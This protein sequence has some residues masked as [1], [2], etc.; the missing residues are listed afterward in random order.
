VS[1]L[2]GS[3]SIYSVLVVVVAVLGV[4]MSVVHVVE[5]VLVLHG[6]MAAPL[7]VPVV[8]LLVPGVLL[9]LDLLGHRR[10]FLVIPTACPPHDQD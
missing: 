10:P 1:L 3:N 2:F 4:P 9:V 7:A 8:V 6:V 5:V